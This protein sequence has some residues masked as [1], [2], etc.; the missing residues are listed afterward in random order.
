MVADQAAAT[1]GRSVSVADAKTHLSELLTAVEAG[2]T[3]QIT[4]RGKPVATLAPVQRPRMPIDLDELRALTDRMPY[5]DV[6]AAD[7]VRQ[8]RDDARY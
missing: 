7:I 2:E 1:L 6:S 4:R 8:M 3:V 5:S